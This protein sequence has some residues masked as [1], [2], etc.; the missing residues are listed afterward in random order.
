MQA[1]DLHLARLGLG[2]LVERGVDVVIGR[3]VDVVGRAGDAVDNTRISA[4][5]ERFGVRL[6]GVRRNVRDYEFIAANVLRPGAE[7]TAGRAL[8]NVPC[9]RERLGV[10]APGTWHVRQAA[11][12]RA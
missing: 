10:C 4:A 3:S 12:P 9:E 5:G 2:I 8:M 11:P 6:G 7:F 1:G